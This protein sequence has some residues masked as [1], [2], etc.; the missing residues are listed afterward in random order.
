MRDIKVVKEKAA[1]RESGAGTERLAAADR[2]SAAEEEISW[3]A[4]EYEP[5]PKDI[6]W[7]WLSIIV[8]TFVLAV[9]VWQRNFLFG[10][11]VVIA[12]I[13]L[14]VWG[15]REPRQINFSVSA[16]GLTISNGKFYPWSEVRSWSAAEM[17]GWEYGDLLFNFKS[18][19]QLSLR[20]LV[21]KDKLA[22]VKKFI[23][24]KAP[25]EERQESVIDSLGRLIGF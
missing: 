22:G 7:F 8:A 14:L 25:E 5:R 16:A 15:N 19:F 12:E 18:S 6:S 24:T 13:L 4:P 9:A 2:D 23:A 11:F 17:E 1:G 3:A 20:V 21:P 10:V